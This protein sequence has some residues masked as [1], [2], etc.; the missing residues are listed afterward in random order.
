MQQS[1]VETVKNLKETKTVNRSSGSSSINHISRLFDYIAIL[2]PLLLI[3]GWT[4][5]FIGYYRGIKGE[6]INHIQLP[7]IGNIGI[8]LYPQKEM[9]LT[10]LLYSLL[11][12][13]IYILNQITDSNTDNINGKL[14]LI[15]HGY[16]NT[17]ILKLQ[18]VILLSLSFILTII[19]FGSFLYSA[20]VLLSIIMGVMYSVSPI[21]LK[22]KPIIDMITNALG[23]GLIAFA[24]GWTSKSEFSSD[25]IFDSLPYFL[26]VSSAFINTTIPDMD[27]D[28]RNGDVTTGIYLGI[29]KSC[30][31]STLILILA[32]IAGLFRKDFVPVTASILSLP[33]FIYMT[34]NNWHNKNIKAIT[35]ATKVSVMA[36]SLLVTLLMPFYFVLLILTII[37]VRIYYQ[38]RFGISYP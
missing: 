3:P 38:L 7:I 14:Y 25:L 32:I 15:P 20:F 24:V 34:I 13:A 6:L 17:K 37:L 4:M 2:R 31:L 29:R 5:L 10:L 35:I 18:I 16:L 12:G 1:K 36:L 22:G 26:C 23:F 11:M 19:G 27:G 30:L 21:R 8:I 9:L 28:A 33:F